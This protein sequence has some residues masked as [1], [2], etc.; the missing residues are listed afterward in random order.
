MFVETDKSM[1]IGQDVIVS[2]LMPESKEHIN[3]NCRVIRI[4]PDG[5]GLEFNS[6]VECFLL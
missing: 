6:P 3:K 5:V 2:F 4:L 1:A